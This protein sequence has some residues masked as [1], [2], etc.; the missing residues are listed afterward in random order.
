MNIIAFNLCTESKE[1]PVNHMEVVYEDIFT[2]K[3]GAQ[4][5]SKRFQ[6]TKPESHIT[7]CS[8]DKSYYLK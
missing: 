4:I 2:V 5:I 1:N 3:S 6:R 7:K 8:R